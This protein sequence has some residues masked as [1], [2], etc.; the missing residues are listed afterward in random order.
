MKSAGYFWGAVLWGA[1]LPALAGVPET[2]QCPAPGIPPGSRVTLVA[3]RSRVDGLPLLILALHT[4]MSPAHL[5]DWYDQHWKGIGK[6]PQARFYTAGPWAVVARKKAG[7]FESIQVNPKA[8]APTL[9][10]LGISRPGRMRK[11]AAASAHFPV[12]GGSH[13]LLSM[14]SAQKQH[15][16]NLLFL[17]PGSPSETAYYYRHTLPHRGWAL[18]MQHRTAAGRALMFQRGDQHVDIALTAAGIRTDVFVT[19][20]HD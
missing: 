1:T 9:A 10:Y 18:Q 12:P 4:R 11:A 19:I 15:S 17:A 16:R 5:L 14:A 8:S 2:A 13:L 6:I 3:P 20:T 7:C